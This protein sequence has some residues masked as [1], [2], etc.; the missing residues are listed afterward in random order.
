MIIFGSGNCCKKSPLMVLTVTME[1]IKHVNRFF[2]QGIDTTSDF[3]S[4]K[5]L[6]VQEKSVEKLQENQFLDV[7]VFVLLASPQV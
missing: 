3:Y 2:N 1:F 6:F 7:Y 5:D 4:S